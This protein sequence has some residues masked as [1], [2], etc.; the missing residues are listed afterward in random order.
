MEGYEVLEAANGVEGIS[1]ARDE[2]PDLILC[3]TMMPERAV[4]RC[5]RPFA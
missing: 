2:L 3:D 5:S 4:T 1:L